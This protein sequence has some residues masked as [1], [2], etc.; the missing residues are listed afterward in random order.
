MKV[1]TE[2]PIKDAWQGFRRDPDTCVDYLDEHLGLVKARSQFN[3]SPFRGMGDGVRHE[4]P[5]GTLQ[6]RTVYLGR[7][8]FLAYVAGQAHTSVRGR[9]VIVLPHALKEIPQVNRLQT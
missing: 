3:G 2:E 6:Q 4:I 8:V 5:H 9:S 7:D 1:D